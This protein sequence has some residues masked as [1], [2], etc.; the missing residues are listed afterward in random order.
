M[1]RVATSDIFQYL[2]ITTIDS[3][4]QS[5]V[6]AIQNATGSPAT[7][8]PRHTSETNA[9]SA[10]E[11]QSRSIVGNQSETETGSTV[12]MLPVAWRV[13]H[14]LSDPFQIRDEAQQFTLSERAGNASMVDDGLER[15]ELPI[16][17]GFGPA[18]SAGMLNHNDQRW[19]QNDSDAE[20]PG[21]LE[22]AEAM[23]YVIL[24]PVY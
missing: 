9:G 7:V 5:I 12:A 10:D 15:T 22:I 21:N 6:V 23:S 2:R 8:L 14:D 19:Q 13:A 11:G 16:M 18:R 3:R 20:D 4:I 1:K 24:H 17:Q